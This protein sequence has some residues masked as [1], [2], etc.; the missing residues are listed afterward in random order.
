MFST[1]LAIVLLAS[2]ASPSPAPASTQ[3]V[4]STTQPVTTVIVTDGKPQDPTLG[5]IFGNTR[6]GQLFQG[7]TRVTLDDVKDPVF[8]IDTI[9]DL[10][11]AVLI[12]IPRLIVAVLFL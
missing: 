6:F 11:L 5:Q 10:A 7:K 4:V 12:F 1:F 3:P 8:W 9:R 2:T